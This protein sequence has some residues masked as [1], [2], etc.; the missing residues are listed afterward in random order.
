MEIEILS[1]TDI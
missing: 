1:M